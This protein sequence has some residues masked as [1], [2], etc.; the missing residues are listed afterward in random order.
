M[1][2]FIKKTTVY[3]VRRIMKLSKLEPWGRNAVRVR[4][5]RS[6]EIK[7]DWISALINQGDD[8]AV[9]EIDPNG[10]SLQNGEIKA[11]INS[12]G[13][14]SFI[15]VNNGKELLKEKPIH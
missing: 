5:T 9:I 1:V 4:C 8:Q 2:E 3:F 6:R 14:L 12:K 15:N 13:E 11:S 7:R 10:A